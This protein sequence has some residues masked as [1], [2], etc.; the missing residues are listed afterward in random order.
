MSDQANTPQ[1][2][3]DDALAALPP[4]QRKFVV[5]YLRDL[6]GQNAAI[7]A[8]YA[9]KAARVQASRLLTNVNVRAAVEA[10]MTLYTMPAP[11]VLYRLTEQARSSIDDFADVIE[12]DVSDAGDMVEA[13]AIAGGWRLNLAKAKLRGK[14]HLIKKIKAGQWGPEI[15]LYDAQAALALLGKH[16]R[17]FVERQEITGKDGQPIEVNDARDRLLRRLTRRAADADEGGAGGSGGGAD[18]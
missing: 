5:E 15:E 1:Q 10:G 6:H 8:G 11:E 13:K 3:F 2:I 14:L 18:G 12:D 16:H 9:E 4:K 17:L 7:R